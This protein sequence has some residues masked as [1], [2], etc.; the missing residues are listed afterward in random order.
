MEKINMDMTRRRMFIGTAA[1]LATP[2]IT[3]DKLKPPKK[4]EP[5]GV[6][7]AIGHTVNHKTG[8][9]EPTI[10]TVN[11]NGDEYVVEVD[12]FKH[13]QGRGPVDAEGNVWFTVSARYKVRKVSGNTGHETIKPKIETLTPSGWELQPGGEVNA[14]FN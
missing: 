2:L 4:S 12:W 14:I 1:L 7:F 6:M 10:Q 5:D 8:V 13:A 3:L 11:K 9:M